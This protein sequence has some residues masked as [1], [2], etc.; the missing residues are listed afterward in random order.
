MVERAVDLAALDSFCSQLSPEYS[1]RKVAA[2]LAGGDP[3]SCKRRV[4]DQAHL[5]ESIEHGINRS[6]GHLFGLECLVKLMSGT[7]SGSQLAQCDG[8][9]HRLNIGVNLLGW[10]E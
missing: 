4:I 10:R 3:V 6:P 7:R 9:G 8:T 5:F 2:L 1:T